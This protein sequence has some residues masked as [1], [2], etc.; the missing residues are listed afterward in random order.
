MILL[1][2]IGTSHLALGIETLLMASAMHTGDLGE[3]GG[4]VK[5][6]W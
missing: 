2:T 3:A 4:T 5:Y 6:A 1:V